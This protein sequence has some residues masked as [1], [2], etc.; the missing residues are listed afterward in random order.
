MCLKYS[1]SFINKETQRLVNQINA[2]HNLNPIDP[3]GIECK[4]ELS[5]IE[6]SYTKLL[7]SINNSNNIELDRIALQGFYSQFKKHDNNK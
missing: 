6:K 3:K 7:E 4:N 5:K 1:T 2:H